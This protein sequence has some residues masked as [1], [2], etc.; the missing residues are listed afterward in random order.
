MS[1]EKRIPVKL[2]QNSNQNFSL[3]NQT[4]DSYQSSKKMVCIVC[5]FH[6]T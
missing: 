6:T 5:V 4:A 1:S 3:S 2:S